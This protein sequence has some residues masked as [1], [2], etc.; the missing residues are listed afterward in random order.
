MT[1]TTHPPPESVDNV[2]G[3]V[4]AA[5][6]LDMKELLEFLYKAV[7]NHIKNKGAEYNFRYFGF[8]CDFK[9]EAEQKKFEE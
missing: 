7:V 6:H 9:S 1:T 4:M 5:K 3:L 8:Q 2:S